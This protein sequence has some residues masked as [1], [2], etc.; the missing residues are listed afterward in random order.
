MVSRDFGN[1]H[2]LAIPV[3]IRG[4]VTF[5]TFDQLDDG[6]GIGALSLRTEIADDLKEPGA[7]MTQTASCRTAIF[8]PRRSPRNF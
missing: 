7:E 5:V 2:W 6:I 8:A 4:V 1:S 3:A